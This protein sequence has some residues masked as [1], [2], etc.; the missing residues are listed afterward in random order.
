MTKLLVLFPSK[1]HFTQSTRPH[2]IDGLFKAKHKG[3][4]M[5]QTPVL[6]VGGSLVGL[7]ASL[8]LAWRGVPHILV[9]KH[10]GS[11]P[12]PRAMGYTETTLEHYRMVGI[13][14]QIPQTPQDFRLRRVRATSL[15]G[16]WQIGR[17]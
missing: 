6:I 3:R 16:E 4:I 7:S 9:E 8:F 11:S 13:A 15:A 2:S 5:L 1:E 12:H 10:A 14:D 17:A